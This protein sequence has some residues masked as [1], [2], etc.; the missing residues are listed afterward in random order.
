MN[1]SIRKI[2]IDPIEFLPL[3]LVYV[4]FKILPLRLSS[5]LGGLMARTICPLLP[6]HKIGEM[7][8]KKAFPNWSSKKRAATLNRAWDNLGRVVGEF[9]HLKKIAQKYTEVVDLAGL[10]SLEKEQKSKVFFSAHMANWEIPHL[11]LMDRGMK[12]SLLSR[13]PNNWLTR[14]F[15][16][17]V[18]HDPSVSIILKGREG[19]KGGIIWAFCW[20]RDYQKGTKS[21]FLEETH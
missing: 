7:N 15:F 14:L 3:F 20:I 17:K 11:I 18:R 1:K 12:I 5:Y 8:L 9:P 10:D 2:F 6:V 21:L 19:S 13:P 4:V 16:M